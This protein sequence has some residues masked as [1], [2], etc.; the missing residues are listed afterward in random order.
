M[1]ISKAEINGKCLIHSTN[2]SRRRRCLTR[3]HGDGASRPFYQ[4]VTAGRTSEIRWFELYVEGSRSLLGLRAEGNGGAGSWRFGP[5]L[6]IWRFPIPP[7][8]RP[9][10]SRYAKS[11]AAAGDCRLLPH[12]P[13]AVHPRDD[14]RT[15]GDFPSP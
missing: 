15:S 6:L 3:A 5:F 13:S 9:P 7:L 12:F 4:G 10:F 11:L 1:S 14:G 8:P 2:L